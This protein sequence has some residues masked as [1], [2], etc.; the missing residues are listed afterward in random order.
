MIEEIVFEFPIISSAV[1][2]LSLRKILWLLKLVH[3]SQS[4]LQ[5]GF[6]QFLALVLLGHPGMLRLVH[7]LVLLQA[8]LDVLLIGDEACTHLDL[9]IGRSELDGISN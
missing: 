7:R 2:F 3:G 1:E 4:L 5:R 6:K 9:S 8:L